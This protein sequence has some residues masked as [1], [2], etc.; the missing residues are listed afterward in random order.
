MQLLRGLPQLRR[1]CEPRTS[2]QHSRT[3]GLADGLVPKVQMQRE[4]LALKWGFFM[5]PD[6]RDLNRSADWSS[7]PKG[8][9]NKI[10]PAES[11]QYNGAGRWF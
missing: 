5:L 7:K 8:E 4:N 9:L 2:R 1:I 11:T 3:L 6:I 10:R